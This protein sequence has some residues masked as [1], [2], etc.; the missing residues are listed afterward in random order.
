M[1]KRVP[2]FINFKNTSGFKNSFR[3]MYESGTKKEKTVFLHLVWGGKRRYGGVG[4]KSLC[5]LKFVL[6]WIWFFRV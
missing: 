5:L 3:I 2:D 4:R 1:Q 6:V